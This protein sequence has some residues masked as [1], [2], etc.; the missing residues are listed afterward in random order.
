VVVYVVGD[1]VAVPWMVFVTI[2]V[3]VSVIV[4]TG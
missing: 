3:R 4:E 2:E 1:G